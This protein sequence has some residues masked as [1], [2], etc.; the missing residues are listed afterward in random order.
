VKTILI[1]S[2]PGHGHVN[3]TLAV[4][5][6]LVRRGNKVIYYNSEDF[7]PPVERSGAEF[8]PYPVTEFS[9]A[10]FSRYAQGSLVRVTILL[11]TVSLKLFPFILDEFEREKPDLVIYDSICLWG[12][13][14]ARQLR[15]PTVA[16][17]TTFVTEGLIALFSWREKL[18][19]VRDILPRIPALV[20]TK[21]EFERLL[22]PDRPLPKPIFPCRGDLNIVYTA[23]SLQPPTPFVDDSF[24]FVGPSITP[25]GGD[26]TVE[27]PA[28]QPLVYISLGTINN[29]DHDFY[30]A[31]LRTLAGFPGRIVLSVGNAIDIADLGPIPDNFTVRNTVPQLAVLPRTAVF[32]THGGMN[33]LHEA[34]YYGVPMVFLP[35]QMEQSLNAKIAAGQ[36]AGLIL[37]MRA[38]RKNPGT[39]RAAIELVL[40]DNRFKTAADALG[41]AL[42]RTG[43]YVAAAEAIEGVGEVA[44]NPSGPK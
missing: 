24:R 21:R 25:R 11:F 22:G 34:L 8:R 2:V 31:C 14:A 3:P 18:A 13:C 36:G 29:T 33:S 5:A 27:S 38:V 26:F 10:D 19:L 43:G 7:R 35:Q 6:E 44:R 39:L 17:I 4:V 37:A 32:V 30:R 23:R 1:T 9:G 41:A 42:R 12:W 16:S 40:A 15:L 28:D 20:R